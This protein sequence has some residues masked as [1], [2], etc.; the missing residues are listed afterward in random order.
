MKHIHRIAAVAA[1]VLFAFPANAMDVAT[2][3]GPITID[4][5]PKTVAVYDVA[6]IDTLSRLGVHLAG[7]PDK[8]YVPELEPAKEGAT[9]VGTLFEPDL[10]ALSALDPDLIIVGSRSAS[11]ADVTAKVAPTIDMTIDGDDLFD[12][13]KQRLAAY[14]E[15]FGKQAE[16]KAV[17]DELD[18]RLAAAKAAIAGKGKAL[19]V[20]SNGP[21]V[22]TYGPGS[23]FGWVHA[24]LDLPAAVS[25]IETA[26]HGEAVSFEF[27]RQANPDWLLV[28]DRA[29]AVGS[30]EQA[31]KVTLDNELIAAT[32]AWKKGQVVYLPAPD[33]YIAAG[34]VQSLERVLT[35]ITEAFAAAK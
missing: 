3:R 21:K 15:L 12:Q 13:A 8:L 6:A 10:E 28:L 1:A 25:E 22:S 35:T 4:G 18:A 9:P 27:I 29:A 2:A 30:N 34:G 19:I 5:T 7:L 32:T 23:R 14:G 26:T 17:A 20:M 31:A 16:A 11:K 33:F 24:A